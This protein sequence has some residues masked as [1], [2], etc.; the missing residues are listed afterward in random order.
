MPIPLSCSSV[1]GLAF[2]VWR[3]L[4]Q[5]ILVNLKLRFTRLSYNP[6]SWS[7]PSCSLSHSGKPSKSQMQPRQVYE[8]NPSRV[9]PC[10]AH[11][12]DPQRGTH[13]KK[14]PIVVH[15]D[16]QDHVKTNPCETQPVCLE[17]QTRKYVQF[18]MSHDDFIIATHT[19]NSFL[20]WTELAGVGWGG[21]G[22][23][24]N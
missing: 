15:I 14:R 11:K 17:F 21:G 23:P 22:A 9:F 16:A 18:T 10:H 20:N 7:Q 2:N 19:R 4:V 12:G 3:L 24:D 1:W 6:D 8:L 13:K 5:L